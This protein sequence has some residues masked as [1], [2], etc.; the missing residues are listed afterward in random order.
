VKLRGLGRAKLYEA[1]VRASSISIRVPNPLAPF[2][3]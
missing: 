1:A 3:T 2:P